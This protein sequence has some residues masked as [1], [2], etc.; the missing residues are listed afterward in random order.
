M[1]KIAHY[2]KH[3]ILL[4][5]SLCLL[6]LLISVWVFFPSSSGEDILEVRINGKTHATFPLT[7][8]L[9]KTITTDN[10]NTNQFQIQDAHVQMIHS[11]C[12]DY[13]CMK[14]KKISKAGETIVCLPHR[15]VLAIVSNDNKSSKPDAVVQ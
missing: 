7:H 2:T 9:T 6:G 5:V 11:N 3:D 10:G 14:T 1:D 4:I 12:N 15:L 8:N 13:T